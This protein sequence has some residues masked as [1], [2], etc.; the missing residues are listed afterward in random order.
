M[1]TRNTPPE[2]GLS[3]GPMIV[4]CQWNISSPTGPNQSYINKIME[5][6]PM[7]YEMNKIHGFIIILYL[8][9]MKQEDL[10]ADPSTLSEFFLMPSKIIP[11]FVLMKT[12]FKI[13]AGK[14][15][16]DLSS[17]FFCIDTYIYIYDIKQRVTR[18]DLGIHRVSQWKNIFFR[19]TPGGNR[20]SLDF[21]LPCLSFD[22]RKASS[23]PF[24]FYRH[25]Y[26][27]DGS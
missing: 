23:A 5:I 7:H 27:T 4:A 21:L 18:V 25:S 10:S 24:L 11:H 6:H 22:H 2:Q 15:D 3:F 9:C 17:L 13:V 19:R 26:S 16:S 20:I 12:I 8:H 1:V 14:S